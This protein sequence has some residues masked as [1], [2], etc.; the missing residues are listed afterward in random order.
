MRDDTPYLNFFLSIIESETKTR[1]TTA[2]RPTIL[3]DGTYSLDLD[4]EKSNGHF[5]GMA[6]SIGPNF[7]ETELIGVMTPLDIVL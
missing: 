2:T 6:L 7:N 1:I 3:K 4:F 5:K